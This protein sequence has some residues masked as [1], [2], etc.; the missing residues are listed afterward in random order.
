MVNINAYGDHTGDGES[1]PTSSRSASQRP[2]TVKD[3]AK[4]AGVSP[5]T[6]SRT[7]AGGQNVR[8][9]I[10]ALVL[11]AVQ[12]LG[13]HRNDNARRMRVNKGSGLVGVAITNLANPYYASFALGVE[14][15]AAQHGVRIIIG[16]TGEDTERERQL[17]ADFLGR[18]VEGLVL[19]PAGGDSEHLQGQA[20]GGTPLVL[21]SRALEGVDADTVLVDD[22][23]GAHAG[24]TALLQ[25]G[26]RRI[27]YLGNVASVSTGHRR[28]AGFCRAFED[29][30]VPLDPALVKRGQQDVEAAQI[31]MT[32]LLELED[33]PT[34]VFCANNRNTIGALKAI[35]ARIQERGGIAAGPAIVSFDDFELAELMPVPIT[36]VDHDARQLGRESA[37]LLFARMAPNGATAATREIEMPTQLI[38]VRS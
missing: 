14:E 25:A 37:T 16:S 11:E 7:I 20:L 21:A 4:L 8:P 38:V 31:S 33:P 36:I 13:Y 15:V 10:Q 28:Y 5:M 19:V 6:V 35:G 22:T 2:A 24:T 9:E 23:G 26:H 18:Q 3:V 32:A 17:V 30:G 12:A 29:Y 34:A 27:A 1:A